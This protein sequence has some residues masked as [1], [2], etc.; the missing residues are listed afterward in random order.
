M[1]SQTRVKIVRAQSSILSQPSRALLHG[2]RRIKGTWKVAYNFQ[3]SRHVSRKIN[4]DRH[5]RVGMRRASL[6]LTLRCLRGQLVGVAVSPLFANL[7][8]AIQCL[9]GICL[10][11]L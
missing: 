6:T 5:L 4:N 1:Q 3:S 9:P 7:L 2:M 10:I 8:S 11:L